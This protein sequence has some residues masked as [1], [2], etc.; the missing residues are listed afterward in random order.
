[1]GALF[2]FCITILY[3]VNGE[4]WQTINRGALD[5]ALDVPVVFQGRLHV[6]VAGHVGDGLD[7][8]PGIE[9]GRDE[10]V[11]QVIGPELSLDPGLALGLPP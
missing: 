2:G 3:H 5:L 1:M 4:L 8:R 10:G 11:A 7:V 9:G 6:R